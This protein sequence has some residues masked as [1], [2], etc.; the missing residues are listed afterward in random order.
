ML[1]LFNYAHYRVKVTEKDRKLP[2]YTLP[3]G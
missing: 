2:Q 1:F 3:I